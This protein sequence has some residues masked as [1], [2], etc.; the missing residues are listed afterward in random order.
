MRTTVKIIMMVFIVIFLA[1]ASLNFLS[2]L[3]E[4]ASSSTT[5][6]GVWQDNGAGFDC[7]GVGTDCD[8]GT[9]M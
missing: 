9:K 3:L 8:I 5:T 1:I 2:P 7:I 6:K 4:S